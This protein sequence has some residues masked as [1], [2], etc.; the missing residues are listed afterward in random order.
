[1]TAFS[2][3][4]AAFEGFRITREKPKAVLVWALF[5]LIVSVVSALYL[6]SIGAEARELLEAS[7]ASETP[8]PAAF[9]AMMQVM[10][11]L[12]IP[13]ILVQCVMAGAV[14]RIL[15]RPSEKGVGYLRL[16]MDEVRLI[17]LTLIYVVI[18]SVLLALVVLAAGVIAVGAAALGRDVAIFVGVAAEVFFLG[19][20]FFI[21]VRLSLA[22]AIT[23]AEH[24][25]AILDSWKL[26]HGQ[27]WRLTGA[28]ALAVAAIVV[29]AVL[30]LVIFGALAAIATGGDLAAAGRAFA[31]DASSVAAYFVPLTIAYLVM[32]AVL[33]ALN[34]A[35]L[36]APAAVA[37]L[38][39]KDLPPSA[40]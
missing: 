4:D 25:L 35:V 39:L 30:C 27:F 26:T 7:A 24:R 37:Y 19:L 17:I 3:T 6:I 15:L 16:G 14:Y 22:P 20:L 1:M 40:L 2:P 11:P 5:S 12:M 13:G 9:V 36:V 31:P 21:A 23:F 29:V 28:Y 18:A 33:S 34:Y 8:D 38:A 10:A 32:A